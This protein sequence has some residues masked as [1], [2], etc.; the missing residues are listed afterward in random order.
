M[1][2]SGRIRGA[3][4]ACTAGLDAGSR[5]EEVRDRPHAHE[6]ADRLIDLGLGVLR[7][8]RGLQFGPRVRA[9]RHRVHHRGRHVVHGQHGGRRR[10][11]DEAAPAGL[12]CVAIPGLQQAHRGPQGEEVPPHV[13]R[14]G[15]DEV[16]TRAKRCGGCRRRRARRASRC[17]RGDDPDVADVVPVAGA[18][19][20]RSVRRRREPPARAVDFAHELHVVIVE[21]RGVFLERP[22]R[23]HHAEVEVIFGIGL[24]IR[25]VG[26]AE[27]LELREHLREHRAADAS[28]VPCRA[29]LDVV[30]L[31]VH[32]EGRPAHRAADDEVAL[33]NRRIVRDGDVHGD[34]VRRRAHDAGDRDAAPEIDVGRRESGREVLPEDAE[35]LARGRARQRGAVEA[36]HHRL[37]ADAGELHVHAEFVVAAGEPAAGD[38]LPVTLDEHHLPQR[39]R[40]VCAHRRAAAPLISRVDHRAPGAHHRP[41]GARVGIGHVGREFVG[42]RAG[43]DGH[44]AEYRALAG[45]A[46]AQG[47]RAVNPRAPHRRGPGG[48][49]R[50]LERERALQMPDRLV[51]GMAVV[52]R[53][54][55]GAGLA[56]G[57]PLPAKR[58][59]VHEGIP[60]AVHRDQQVPFGVRASLEEHASH[61]MAARADPFGV[62]VGGVAV[63]D[64]APLDFER[65]R[66]RFFGRQAEVI[67]RGTSRLRAPARVRSPPC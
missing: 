28:H 39:G 25:T 11:V 13:E 37:P 52:R 64:Q 57:R 51:H 15:H 16:R 59:E 19:R 43:G 49:F 61:R 18:Q 66:L 26:V 38:R 3:G 45:L 35:G 2:V 27:G 53:T 46:A 41:P 7:A 14:H 48:P 60:A 33:A 4:R 65:G 36:R 17:M 20:I 1:G 34:H 40:V 8:Q 23:R 47:P 12:E 55:V 62:A 56:R 5:G 67:G 9:R 22:D 31:V 44:A 24:A 29:H 42:R 30:H 58:L 63:V 32:R 10:E 54:P 50:G 6:L 21:G